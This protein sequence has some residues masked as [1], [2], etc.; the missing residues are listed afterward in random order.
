MNKLKS[1]YIIEVN[2]YTH[3]NYNDRMM[4]HMYKTDKIVFSEI[5]DIKKYINKLKFEL[6]YCLGL[7]EYV[8]YEGSMQRIEV[9]C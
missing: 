4:R 2:F 7:I 1:F 6:D 8:V 5:S 3:E 9:D